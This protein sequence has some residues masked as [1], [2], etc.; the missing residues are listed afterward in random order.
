MLE[1]ME[2]NLL[3]L[4][5]SLRS[6]NIQSSISK[7]LGD[8]PMMRID[9]VPGEFA[10]SGTNLYDHWWNGMVPVRWDMSCEDVTKLVMDGAV[11]N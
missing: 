9:G 1:E 8:V 4:Q 3:G 11:A 6:R 7:G 5:S 10:A 2:R